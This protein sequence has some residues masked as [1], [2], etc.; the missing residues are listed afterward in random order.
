MD[1]SNADTTL[2][3]NRLRDVVLP[4]LR[5]EVNP[6]VDDAL[7]RLG[8]QARRNGQAVLASAR[9]LADPKGG[10]ELAALAKAE[11]AVCSEALFELATRCA[12]GRVEARHVRAL[13]RIVRFGRG[14]L[15]LPGGV[16]LGVRKGRL[17]RLSEERVSQPH[18]S[19]SLEVGGAT[20]DRA[21]GLEFSA[22]LVGRPDDLHADPAKR[23][24][25]DA[26]RVRGELSVRRRR[27]GDRFWPLGAPGRRSLKRFLIDQKVP[28]EARDAIPV[29]TLDDRPVWIVGLRMDDHYKVT[30]STAQVLELRASA[31]ANG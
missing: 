6:L 30:P 20:L 21:A 19:L 26:S 5:R 29:V 14:A 22:R 13:E 7:L 10:L 17:V 23:V 31:A 25:L 18:E 4:F 12:P 24:L 3:R 8:R 2:T 9:A 11:P 1:P 16:R 28:R 27:P 15:S